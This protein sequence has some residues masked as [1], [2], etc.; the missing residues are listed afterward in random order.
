MSLPF[1]IIDDVQESTIVRFLKQYQQCVF[2]KMDE[3]INLQ[4]NKIICF[5][6]NTNKTDLLN[7]MNTIGISEYYISLFLVPK[8]IEIGNLSPHFNLVRFPIKYLDFN[9]MILSI[10]RQTSNSYQNLYLSAGSI[11][12]NKKNNKKIFMTETEMKILTIL[13]E[14]K[15]VKKDLLRQ[16]ILHF[17]PGV[18]SKSLES[19]LS[20][21]RK[22]IHEIGGVT[23]IASKNS[24]YIEIQ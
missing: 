11:L 21:I 13:F 19:H 23:E 17:Q 5:K 8:K 2:Y 10:S 15:T 6:D 12:A 4:T 18:D 16:S 14:K 20:R 3:I 24:I 9:K 1:A 7:I 22:K